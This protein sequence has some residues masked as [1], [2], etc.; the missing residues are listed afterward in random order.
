MDRTRQIINTNY[1]V[2]VR[3]ASG[4]CSIE[5]TQ[6]SG[7]LYSFTMTRGTDAIPPN[8]LG[9]YNSHANAQVFTNHGSTFVDDQQ[10]K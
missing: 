3:A 4:Y 8:Y 9:K 1:G 10:R 7:D 6:T 5:W 2:F